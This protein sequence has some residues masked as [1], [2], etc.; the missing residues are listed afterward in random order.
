[1]NYKVAAVEGFEAAYEKLIKKM[2]ANNVLVVTGSH[3][4]VGKVLSRFFGL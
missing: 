3:F 1:M 2:G 4:L